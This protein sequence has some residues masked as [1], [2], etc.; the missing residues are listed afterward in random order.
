MQYSVS[1]ESSDGYPLLLGTKTKCMQESVLQILHK[2]YAIATERVKFRHNAPQWETPSDWW[3][4]HGM[5]IPAP[6]VDIC[7]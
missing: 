4:V 1:R 3:E 5:R 2:R 7:Q 6:L